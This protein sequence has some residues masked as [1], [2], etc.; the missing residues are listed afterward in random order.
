M[1]HWRRILTRSLTLWLGVSGG[2]FCLGAPAAS[3]SGAALIEAAQSDD[4]AAVAALLRKK[5]DV[6][7]RE[8]DGATALAWAALR[9]NREIA[10]MLLKAGADPNARNDE[11]IGPLYV[12]IANGSPALA[13]LL[14]ENGADPNLPRENGET[15]LMAAT[16]LGQT[17]VMKKLL[18]RGANVNAREKK[19]DQT[20]LMWA[21]GH[22]EAVR[23]LVEHGADV[24][25][26][27]KVWDITATIYT[28]TTSTIGKTGIPWNNDGTYTSKQGGQ[29]A[30]LF[31]VQQHDLESARILLDAGVDVN[32]A[33]ADGTTPL[34]A[35]LYKWDPLGKEFEA[36]KGA[37]APAG[38]SA[39]FGADLAMARFLLDRGAKVSVADGAGYTPLHGAALAVASITTLGRDRSAYGGG[40]AIRSKGGSQP[41][42]T[43]SAARLKEA[44]ALVQRL[45]DA[46]ADPN[47]QTL[48]PTSGP[49]GDVRINPAPPGSSAF[50]IAGDS[51]CVELVRMLAE[52]GAKP[53]LLRKDGHTPFS[54]SVLSTDLAV[55]KEMVARGADLSARYNPTDRFADPVKPISLPRREQTIL[56]I[57]A[58]AAA[59]EVIEY[60]AS[61]GVSLDAR[62]SAGET[63][64]DLADHQER[65]RE[66]RSREAAEDKPDRTVKRDTTTTDV[67]KK[68]MSGSKAASV[69]R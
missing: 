16:R 20:A 58:A 23:L 36:G 1:Q 7:A 69:A 45:L 6:N 10:A 13:E 43:E 34:L 52:K 21:A 29:N 22:P 3:G 66:A 51:D 55:V 38:S 54:V 60:L 25:A 47:R 68:L 27:S 8:D 5:V 35:A 41:A 33:S 37:P 40:R 64:L 56:H 62:N 15:P 65:Y 39:R 17:G 59:P 19:F 48:Y 32:V 31:A 61:L 12:A 49:V 11:G 44:L 24:H 14:L 57:A 42:N 26:V 4:A 2:M 63:P 30:L 46:G 53:N 67:I 18:D 28:P 9:G 50:H